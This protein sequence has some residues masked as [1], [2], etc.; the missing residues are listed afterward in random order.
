[1]V[2]TRSMNRKLLE[3]PATYQDYITG[4]KLVFIE[5]TSVIYGPK[6]NNIFG[7]AKLMIPKTSR[8]NLDRTVCNKK[9]AKYRTEFAKVE[10]IKSIVGKTKYRRGYSVLKPDGYYINGKY[11]HADKWNSEIDKV[12]TNGIHF[13]LSKRAV[14]SLYQSLTFEDTIDGIDGRLNRQSIRNSIYIKSDD[15]GNIDYKAYYDKSGS[16]YKVIKL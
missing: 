8:T 9:Y 7:I 16:L 11:I 15:N 14:Y 3:D 6:T 13:Y 2:I 12:C 1:M 10:Y 4:Y 5:P